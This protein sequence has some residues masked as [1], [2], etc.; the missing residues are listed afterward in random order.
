MASRA[1]EKE[2]R[3]QER[4]ALEQAARHQQR[5]KQLIGFATGGLLAVAAIAAAVVVV[6][7]GGGGNGSGASS[8]AP[9]GTHYSGLESRREAANV[10]TMQDAQS[11]GAAHFH[12]HITVYLNGKKVKVPTNIGINP[13]KPPFEMAGLHTHDESG[14]IHNE[15]GTQARLGQFFAVWG[16]PFSAR[17][18]GPYRATNAKRVKMWVDGKPSRA[19]GNLQL[20]DGQ[21]IVVSYGRRGDDPF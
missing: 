13:D 7:A 14:T 8:E 18:L 16:V 21:R 9:F 12:P 20:A 10:P 19:F 6:V 15:A 1:A 17:Q 11:V 3:R 4:L 5:R 2:R